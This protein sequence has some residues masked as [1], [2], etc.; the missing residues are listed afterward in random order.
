ML[1]FTF[2]YI[3]CLHRFSYFKYFL[4]CS[5]VPF[6]SISFINLYHAL[7]GTIENRV[8]HYYCSVLYCTVLYCTVLYCTVLYCTVP[9]QFSSFTS[10]LTR[11]TVLYSIVQYSTVQ[12]CTVQSQF[13][14]F[15]S[16]STR[17]KA[18]R[19]LYY[20]LI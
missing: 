19:D 18:A 12:H 16:S 15:T 2:V 10:S 13:S 3:L 9:S 6:P 7:K 17:R 14:S 8:C 11:R 1:I 20:K 5:T 4:V